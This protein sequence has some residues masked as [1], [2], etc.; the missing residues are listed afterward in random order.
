MTGKA[1]LREALE[2]LEFSGACRFDEPMAAHTTFK[3]GGPAEL[4][5][6]PDAACFL[7]FT[8]SLLRRAK[9]LG[10]PVFILGGGANIVA[11]DRG[12]AG[13]VLDTGKWA[14]MLPGRGTEAA[15]TVGP[16]RELPGGPEAAG[17]GTVELGAMAAG[18]GL[19]AFRSGTPAD[20]AACLTAS[21]GLGG[22]EFLAGMPGSIGG[23]VWMNA[24]CYE[25]SVSAVLEETEI[26]D[27]DREVRRVPFRAAD[28]G[29]KKS[30]F[31]NRDV[32]ILSALFHL[33]SRP[34]AELRAVMDAHREDREAKGH[35]R[36]P[37][38]G[39]AFK[40]NRAFGKPT[41]KII[42]ELGLRGLSRGGASIAPWHGNLLIN[43]GCATA[44]D[45]RALTDEVREKTFA[46]L[47][48]NL[49]CEILF[50]G[51]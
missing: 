29:Y 39:S 4:W 26:L 21:L 1:A 46:A 45:I 14:G 19:A 30:P 38:A 2:G 36:F 3:V 25:K 20:Q 13:I 31:Q 22:L 15:G 48:I 28:F 17:P 41:G 34:E 16:G 24:R 51:F 35:Y 37:S 12:I 50:V 43:T 44:A 23:S 33:E 32:L 7:S 49:E 5:I 6:Q 9:A 8:P 40:N 47:G 10:I 27:E 11:A 42:D 18:R